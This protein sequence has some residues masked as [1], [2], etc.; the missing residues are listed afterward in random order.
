M[1]FNFDDLEDKLKNI[2]NDSKKITDSLKKYE[3][4]KKIELIVFTFM[5]IISYDYYLQKKEYLIFINNFSEAYLLG[6]E[7]YINIGD[8]YMF[9]HYYNEIEDKL[10]FKINSFL[11]FMCMLYDS[12][13]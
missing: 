4:K 13:S 7:R 9:Q 8:D 12:L 1:K 5:A 2:I 11:F 3:N 10:K 6:D